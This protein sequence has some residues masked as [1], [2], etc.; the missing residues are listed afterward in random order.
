ME[1]YVNHMANIK[2][3]SEGAMRNI[4][5]LLLN[6]PYGRFGMNNDRDITKIVSLKE[7]GGYAAVAAE[8]LELIFKLIVVVKLNEDKYFVRYSKKP[9]PVK[10]DQSNQDLDVLNI[11]TFNEDIVNNSPATAAAIAS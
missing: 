5:K 10:C 9:D 8:K 1:T 2:D 7:G 11:D 6:T 3:N 4:H